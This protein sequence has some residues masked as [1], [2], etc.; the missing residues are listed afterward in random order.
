VRQQLDDLRLQTPAALTGFDQALASLGAIQAWCEQHLR[1]FAPGLSVLSKLLRLLARPM[2]SHGVHNVTSDGP[3]VFETHV[4]DASVLG[5]EASTE[6][7]ATTPQTVESVGAVPSSRT[8]LTGRQ[9]ALERIREARHWFETHE[10]SSPIPV[11]LKRAEQFVGKRY[12][13][14]VEAIPTE[15]LVK[16]DAD[17]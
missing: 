2:E 11:L 15:L 7:A 6:N 12:A 9:A 14:I 3:A 4:A 17:A 10:P 8:P 16:W 1:S 5:D 13:E